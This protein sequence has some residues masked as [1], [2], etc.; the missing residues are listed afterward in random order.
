[1]RIVIGQDWLNYCIASPPSL[2][3]AAGSGGTYTCAA[4]SARTDGLIAEA[5]GLVRGAVPHVLEQPES[6]GLHVH[7]GRQANPALLI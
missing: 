5:R 3:T 2:N 6:R 1:M 7:V 4:T